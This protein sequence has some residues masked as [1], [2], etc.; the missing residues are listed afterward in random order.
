MQL[1][2]A[3]RLAINQVKAV[4][5]LTRV[6]DIQAARRVRRGGALAKEPSLAACQIVERKL[7]LV[8]VVVVTGVVVCER[9]A[10]AERG[11]R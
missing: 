7:G 4:V 2:P 6:L 10:I 8:I 3:A 1:R 9:V 5:D 11:R